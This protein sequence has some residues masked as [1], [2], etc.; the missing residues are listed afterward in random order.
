[1]TFKLNELQPF[2]EVAS[3]LGQSYAPYTIVFEFVK[4]N[5]M[6]DGIKGLKKIKENTNDMS[7]AIKTK[8]DFFTKVNQCRRN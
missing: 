1:M 7:I 8:W 5:I 2:G 6:I 3:N 4:Q